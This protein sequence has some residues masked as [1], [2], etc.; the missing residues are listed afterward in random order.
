MAGAEQ[1]RKIPL[2]FFSTEQDLEPV[3]E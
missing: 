3:R 2:I 1:A